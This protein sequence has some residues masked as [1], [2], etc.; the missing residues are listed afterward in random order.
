MKKIIILGIILGFF[1]A[2]FGQKAFNYPS[3]PKD[4]TTNIYFGDEVNDPY[5]WMENP[6]D[7]RLTTW[8]EE[9]ESFTDKISHK[10]TRQRELRAQLVAMYNEVN[11]DKTYGYKH[12]IKKFTEKY[13][14]EEKIINDK[15]SSDLLYKHQDESNFKSL[16]RAK[17][18]IEQ[19]GDKLDYTEKIINEEEDLAVVTLSINGSDWN[20][21]YIFNLADG[22]RL[23]PIFNNLKG[24][25]IRWYGNTVYFDAFDVP[26]KGRELLDRAKGQKLYRLEIG[27]DSLPELIY[28]NTDISG[29]SPFR[30]TIQDD[31]LFI[32][33]FVKSRNTFYKAISCADLNT[34]TF[35]PRNF[36]IY[37]NQEDLN[38][39]V[40]HT[41]NDSV[42]LNTNW[43]APNGMVLL[44][45]LN[46]P[47]KL[48]EFVPQ[49]D[50]LL[51][52][53]NPLGKNKL[54]L[55]YLNN[56]QNTALVYNY[57]GELLKK[58]DFPKGKKV[59]YF[60][61]QEDVKYT[62]F[63]ISSFF[64]P[65]LLYQISLQDLNFVPVESLTV[66]YDVSKLETRYVSYPSKDGTEIS[67]YVTCK[68]DIELNGK[69]PVMLYGYG[70]Y[71]SVVEPFFEQS[72]ALFIAHGGILAVPNIRGGGV[73][74]GNWALSGRRLNKQN[75]IDDFIGAAEYLIKE[76]Y[77][78]SDK[79]VASGA[80]HGGLLVT[81]A[82]V[83]R[84]ALFKAV[85]AEAGPYD[86][87]RFHK[88]TVG[89]VNTNILEFGTTD[90][91]EDYHN[92]KSYSPL[93]NIEEGVKYPSLLL[94]T[95]D[96]DDRVPPFHS[97]K[98]VSSLQEKADNSSLYTM[99]VTKGAGHGGT[100]TQA[101]FEELL[102]FK[103]YF[104][105]DNL[106]I[107]FY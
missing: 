63:T 49:Y 18:Y 11:R 42:W 44:A 43:N 32:Y 86:M 10:Q 53:V 26:V 33:H 6:T 66:P 35:F 56:G 52:Q 22:Q 38:L 81:A 16:I 64:H 50:M 29:T 58:I 68:K 30:Y 84:P 76:N 74:G 39:S 103:Y 65:D 48:T 98:F 85:I 88:Y 69:N 93:H 62:D 80:S 47:N 21:G 87:L 96:S 92:L 57:Q 97:F 104:I 40:V 15:K 14:F 41:L 8:L 82:M 61:E 99:F 3:T 75:A 17:E 89:G 7:P 34:S 72:I 1:N 106:G 46:E 9:Q 4:T 71:G 37:P 70:G 105:F 13:E 90:N 20:T 67:M 2:V 60:W 83:Q 102:L 54:A 19:K 51:D 24:A 59:R 25:N 23:P 36:I 5:Q 107:D 100:L 79:I 45:N 95:G 27:K 78:Y 91:Q 101:D 77:T 12:R 94:L 28:T 55:I 31:K 73:K